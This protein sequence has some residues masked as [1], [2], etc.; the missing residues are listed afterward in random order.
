MCARFVVETVFILTIRQAAKP[1]D[2]RSRLKQIADETLDAFDH[3][4]YVLDGTQHD[5]RTPVELAKRKAQYYA[6]DSLLSG[7]ST[8]IPVRSHDTEISVLEVST[9]EGAHILS[10]VQLASQPGYPPSRVGILNFA[11]ATKP[12]GGF[13]TGAQAQEESIARSSTLYPT[14]TTTLTQTFYT[15][16][17]RDRKDCFYTHAMIYSPGVIVFRDDD[18]RW[19]E[20]FDVDVLT[21]AAV[22]AGVAR[23]KL[24]GDSDAIEGKIEKIMRERMARILYLFEKQGVK[25]VV[26]GSFGTGVFR[27]NVN[28]V[29]NIWAD[30]LVETDARFR[31]SFDHV[32]FAILGKATFEEF[33]SVFERRKATKA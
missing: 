8:S 32:V 10:T 3:G 28:L 21:S 13:K 16:H 6:P 30:L 15:T 31:T 29:A 18:G 1:G 5:L 27:N 7:W 23:D 11:S 4:S 20:P 14:L 26:L 25:D 33:E 22:N 19:V 17:A 12:G 2:R 24:K 9:L